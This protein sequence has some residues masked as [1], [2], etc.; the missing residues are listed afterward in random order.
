MSSAL[1][2]YPKQAEFGR[3]VPKNKLYAHARVSAALRKKFLA[4][5]KIVWQYKLSP[6]T[7]NL[8]VAKNVPEIEVFRIILRQSELHPDVL[9]CIDNAIPFPTIYE[10][11]FEDR[12]KVRAAFKRPSEADSSKW[13]TD[14]YFESEWRPIN[15]KRKPLPIALDLG[16]LYEQIL[17]N[18]MPMSGFDGEGI[19]DQVQR[20]TEI[21][22]LETRA[23]KIE[24]RMQKEKQFNRKVELNAEL[25]ALTKEIDNLVNNA[26]QI[27]LQEI[28]SV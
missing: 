15:S 9:K 20:L 14:I 27:P 2:A 17:R 23:A 24:S 25:R 18:L 10:L 5:E 4:I 7:V 21:R 16:L 19:R 26:D 28:S 8:S 11:I 22:H 6:E 13:V 12:L 1:F 3:N